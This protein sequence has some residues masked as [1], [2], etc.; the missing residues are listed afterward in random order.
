MKMFKK[1][2]FIWLI[3]IGVTF[4]SVTKSHAEESE[5]KF[6]LEKGVKYTILLELNQSFAYKI[7]DA[8]VVG[9]VEIGNKTFLLVQMQGLVKEAPALIAVDSV[10][11]ILPQVNLQETLIQQQAGK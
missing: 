6:S 11:A 8:Y 7:K 5:N 3:I 1:I 2:I 9:T 10:K 4:I